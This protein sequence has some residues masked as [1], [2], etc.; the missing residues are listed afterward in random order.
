M[1]G[2]GYRRLA[3]AACLRPSA[4]VARCAAASRVFAQGIAPAAGKKRTESRMRILLGTAFA[5]L[6]LL[7]G[8]VGHDS[9]SGRGVGPQPVKVAFIGDSGFGSSRT[10]VLQLIASEGADAVMH[11]GD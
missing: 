2:R 7:A 8:L 9:D 6:V 1:V 11:Q 3:R 5:G 4:S 10:A